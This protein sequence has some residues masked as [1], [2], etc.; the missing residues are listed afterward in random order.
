MKNIMKMRFLGEDK[1]CELITLES[2]PPYNYYEM[3]IEV[4]GEW[5]IIVFETSVKTKIKQP[6]G[7]KKQYTKL[8]I[9]AIYTLEEREEF[10][11]NNKGLVSNQE[12][13]EIGKEVE[14]DLDNMILDFDYSDDFFPDI[15]QKVMNDLY[16]MK[17]NGILNARKKSFEEA[18]SELPTLERDILPQLMELGQQERAK[19]LY[20]R[21]L[22]CVLTG[23]YSLTEYKEFMSKLADVVKSGKVFISD[24]SIDE[25][26]YNVDHN[27]ENSKHIHVLSPNSRANISNSTLDELADVKNSSKNT[28]FKAMQI[29]PVEIDFSNYITDMFQKDS[30]TLLGRLTDFEESY[31]ESLINCSYNDVVTRRGFYIGEDNKGDI[32]ILE[33][34]DWVIEMQIANMKENS[35]DKET[36]LAS[37]ERQL[38]KLESEGKYLSSY[39]VEIEGEGL[40]IE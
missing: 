20:E 31:I 18:K 8:G 34:P 28:R 39:E 7:L 6:D 30:A 14:I 3:S 4:N 19:K 23:R 32:I 10:E 5:Y 15:Q 21:M 12:V 11:K 17:R 33:Q 16:Q 9:A 26:K 36:K 35:S 13:G 25:I 29:R 27:T 40:N 22:Q 37:R 38:Q 2:R 1:E 24:A